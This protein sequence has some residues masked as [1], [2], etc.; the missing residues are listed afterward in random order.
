MRVSMLCAC[1]LTFDRSGDEILEAS[2]RLRSG[3][4]EHIS[5]VLG[6]A[7]RVLLLALTGYVGAC[8]TLIPGTK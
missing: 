1:L 7:P 5:H 3:F 4:Q 2:A 8:A 6:F